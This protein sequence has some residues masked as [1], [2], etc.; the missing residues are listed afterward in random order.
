MP[1]QNASGISKMRAGARGQVR[2]GDSRVAGSVGVAS[3]QC[4]RARE[5]HDLLVGEALPETQ[6]PQP[7]TQQFIN[8]RPSQQ[9]FIDIRPSQQQFLISGRVTAFILTDRRMRM[10]T[11][12]TCTSTLHYVRSACTCTVN[13]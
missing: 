10:Y 7:R 3:P 8:I 9:K 2:E 11:M 5:R 4:V 1:W 13:M 6:T 12:C